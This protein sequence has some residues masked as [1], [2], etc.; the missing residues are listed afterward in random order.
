MM[1]PKFPRPSTPLEPEKLK[2]VCATQTRLGR[3]CLALS[4]ALP[5]ACSGTVPVSEHVSA[6][7]DDDDP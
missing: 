5:S 2:S 7:A 1:V 3:A 6:G 4:R